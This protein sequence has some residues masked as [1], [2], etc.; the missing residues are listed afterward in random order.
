MS[1]LWIE[2]KGLNK[3]GQRARE[4]FL[5]GL[6]GKVCTVMGRA[7]WIDR[8]VERYGWFHGSYNNVT[9]GHASQP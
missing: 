1:G 3:V 4:E 8:S 6:F 2:A 5:T 7:S 9:M